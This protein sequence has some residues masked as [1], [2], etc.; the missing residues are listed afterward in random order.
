VSVTAY[1]AVDALTADGLR[2]VVLLYDGAIQRLELA[3]RALTRGEIGPFAWHL[4][5]AHAILGALAEALDEAR[6]GELARTLAR[7]YQFMLLQLAGALGAR[8]R[9]PV[10]D[11]LGL[12][13]LLRDAFAAAATRPS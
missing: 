13:R 7:L 8:Q 6:G 10:E 2:L 3:L 5:R 12:L 4:H 1:Q 11:V 9:R